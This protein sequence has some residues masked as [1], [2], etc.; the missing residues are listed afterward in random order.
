MGQQFAAKQHK[1]STFRLDAQPLA[2][3]G[4]R[5]IKAELT[6]IIRLAVGSEVENKGDAAVRLA[7]MLVHVSPVAGSWRVVGKMEF[8]ALQPQKEVSI[9]CLA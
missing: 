8:R 1:S 7:A 9:E 3:G 5:L 4:F 6:P 2:V